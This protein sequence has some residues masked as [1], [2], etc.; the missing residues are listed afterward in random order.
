MISSSANA[1]VKHIRSLAADRRERR[2]ERLFMLEGVRL[3]SD[4][5]DSIHRLELVP[6][7]YTHLDVYKRQASPCHY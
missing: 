5:L 1:H 6:V 7:S 3:I 4:A 2:R